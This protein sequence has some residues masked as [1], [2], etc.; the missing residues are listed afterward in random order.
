MSN[1]IRQKRTKDELRIALEVQKE[2]EAI[3]DNSP[4]VVFLWRAAEGWPVEFVSD[5]IKQFGY[6]PE[7]FISGRIPYAKVVHPDD[8]ERVTAEISEYSK[9]G[10][11]EFTQEY[12]IITRTGD[13]RWL[14]DRTSV[15]RDSN[16]VI[17]HYQGIVVDITQRKRQEEEIKNAYDKLRQ[18]QIQLIQASKMAA[19]GQLASGIAHEINNPLTGILNN[20]QLIKVD[21]VR[22]EKVDLDEF[23]ELFNIIEESA[24]RCKKVVQSVLD[25]SRSSKGPFKLLSL[26]DVIEKAVAFIEYEI[27][28]QN[29][30]IK[31]ELQPDLIP[32]LGD[33]QLLQQVILDI[34]SNARWAILQ[35][36]K[37]EMGLIVIKTQ[38]IQGKNQVLLSISDNGIGI[39]RENLDKI[40]EP[41]F[42]TKR[43]GEGTGLGLS[44]VYNIIKEHKGA[45]EAESQPD[46]GAT[47]KITLPAA[48]STSHV[49]KSKK[50]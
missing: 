29:I 4:V 15:R 1:K 19:V 11:K 5:N 23:K 24:Y 26:N 28:S 30:L 43:A 39:T 6:T 36:E 33:F 21:I 44:I 37:K 13:V 34:V 50:E 20:I 45:I 12:R 32:I 9:K 16:G 27:T 42:T 7:D 38:C 46:E 40:F 3:I 14:D 8:L 17:T 18:T 48:S 31:K 47:F 2:L 41:F 49:D 35:K 10:A 25:F 22:K